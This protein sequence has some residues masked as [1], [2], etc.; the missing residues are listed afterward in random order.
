VNVPNKTGRATT[1]V[2]TYM[3]GAKAV[4]SKSSSLRKATAKYSVNFM[5]LQRLCKKLQQ[6]NVYDKFIGFYSKLAK[7]Y[8]KHRF[9]CRD[10]YSFDET[11]VTTVQ[12]TTRIVEKNG[13]KLVGAVTSAERCCLVTMAVAV[14]PSG[15]SVPPFFLF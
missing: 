8:D 13:V 4:L 6:G 15:N 2:L 5:T 1:T 9:Q 14:S 3:D 7:V 11:A 10:I 12:T